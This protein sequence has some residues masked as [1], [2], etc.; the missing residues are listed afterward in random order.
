MSCL[1]YVI[2]RMQHGI[3]IQRD[4]HLYMHVLTLMKE[5]FL[6]KG[7]ILI[8]IARH[9]NIIFVSGGKFHI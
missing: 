6:E 5:G 7:V 2:A 4:I 3:T 1:A 8:R 9:G